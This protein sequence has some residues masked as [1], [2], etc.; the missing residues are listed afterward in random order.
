MTL[1]TNDYMSHMK[2][3]FVELLQGMGVVPAGANPIVTKTFL[4]MRELLVVDANSYEFVMREISGNDKPLEHKLNDNE[5]F[6]PTHVSIKLRKGDS[7]DAGAKQDGNF[8]QFSY[9]DPAEF[10]GA[11][12]AIKEACALELVYDG[13]LDIESDGTAITKDLMTSLTRSEI[14]N[15]T[16][17]LEEKGF[18]RLDNEFVYSGRGDNKVRLRLGAGKNALIDGSVDAAGAAVTTRNYVE[19]EVLGFVYSK[20]TQDT[21]GVCA[22]S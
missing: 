6:L 8:K 7:D 22:L 13:K 17:D 12:G 11:N 20:A 5:Y 1:L 19:I 10:V 16:A 14:A 21:A 9:P 18:S 2:Q 3:R 15:E 4:R